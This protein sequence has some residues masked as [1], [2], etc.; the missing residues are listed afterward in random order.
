[1]KY[2]NSADFSHKQADKVGVLISN[3]GTPEAPTKQALK[4]Y[5]KQF[6]SDP[7]VVEVPRLIWWFALNLVILNRRPARS[8]EAYKSV[9]SDQGSPLLVHSKNQ[10]EGLRT[11]LQQEYGD[12]IVVEFAM[13]YG[14]PSIESVIEKMLRSGVRKLLVLPLY[15]QYSASTTASTFDAIA[16]L[17]QRR[18]WLPDLRFVSHYHDV[19]EYI[20]ALGE[21]IKQH[22]QEHGQADKLIFSYHG[23]PKKYLDNG[24]PYHCECFKTSRL[25]AQYLELQPEQYQTTF[26]SR[27]GPQEWLQPY[28]DET[29][30]SLPGQGVKRVQVCCPGFSSDCLETIEEIDE[31][32]REYFLH[33]GGEEFQYIPCLNSDDSHIA[34]L[35]QLAMTHLQGWDIPAAA[36]TQKIAEQRA[37]EADRVAK[38][39]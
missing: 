3:L 6:L 34:M 26:Q 13:R 15:P 7:R 21:K 16:Q 18:R 39:N 31:E 36:E 2:I 11:A 8:A 38:Q 22:W 5:L 37:A 12:N 24:D 4:P 28:T 19:P 27:F 32:N 23:V 30:K 33:A 35:K 1:M 20:A 29:L 17:F 25:L 9:W 14:N 10:A